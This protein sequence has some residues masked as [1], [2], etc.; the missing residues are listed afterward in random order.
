MIYHS[1]ER[2]ASEDKSFNMGHVIVQLVFHL[3]TQSLKGDYVF[4]SQKTG[5]LLFQSKKPS[6][7]NLLTLQ[8]SIKRQWLGTAP[9][10]SKS[11]PGCLLLLAATLEESSLTC[12]KPVYLRS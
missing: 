12:K 9:V 4:S 5:K 6:S 10:Q 7:L 3:N 2:V 11:P 1:V 8:R